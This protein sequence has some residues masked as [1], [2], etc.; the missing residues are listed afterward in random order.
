LSKKAYCGHVNQ[1]SCLHKVAKLP[2]KDTESK[3]IKKSQA[4]QSLRE[5]NLERSK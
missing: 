5:K 1:K 3:I 4:K 2:S